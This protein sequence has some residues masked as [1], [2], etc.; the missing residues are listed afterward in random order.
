MREPLEIRK[1]LESATYQS[2]ESMMEAYAKAA[3]EMG[4]DRYQRKLNFSAESVDALD[5]IVVLA[6]ENPGLDVEFE[7]RLWGSYLGEVVRRR[8]AGS[9]EMETYPGGTAAVPAV[10]V[11][12]SL[13]FPVMKVYR[14]MTMGEED[15]L[16]S[17]FAMVAERLG[18]PAQV[19]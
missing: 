19:N 16:Q 7:A 12:G 9:W 2:R 14:R 17:F 6:S 15:D 5:E 4:R 8:Y 11:R 10:R 13:L 3:T 18:K 1:R